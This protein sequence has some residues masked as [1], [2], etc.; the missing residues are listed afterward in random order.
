MLGLVGKY[1]NDHEDNIAHCTTHP[2]TGERINLQP[3]FVSEK[4]EG[5]KGVPPKELVYRP[6]TEED[7]KA[8]SKATNP[9]GKKKNP[10]IGELP[11]H[12]A[13]V[14]KVMFDKAMAEAGKKAPAQA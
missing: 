5:T 9:D 11:D 13:K 3:W 12:I 4:V 8:I 2:E 10:L 1:L 7:F 6:A 14:K